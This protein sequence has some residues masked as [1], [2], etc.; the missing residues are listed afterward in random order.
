MFYETSHGKLFYT[1]SWPTSTSTLKGNFSKSLNSL[2]NKKMKSFPIIINNNNTFSC[3]HSS[4]LS[5]I[6]DEE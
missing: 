1:E 5:S 4:S 2:Y 6:I 3:S